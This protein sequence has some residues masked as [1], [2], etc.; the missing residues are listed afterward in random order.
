MPRDRS[1]AKYFRLPPPSECHFSNTLKGLDLSRWT[2]APVK[3]QVSSAKL[4]LRVMKNETTC[5]GGYCDKHPIITKDHNEL[6]YALMTVINQN[7][8]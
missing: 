4:K 3:H 7:T 6:Q 1:G 8:N 2:A 5:R